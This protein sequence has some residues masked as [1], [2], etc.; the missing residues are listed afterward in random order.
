MTRIN[1]IDPKLLRDK[2]LLAE[3]RELPR[4]FKLIKAAQ[5]RGEMPDD[6]RNPKEYKLGT[7][8]VRFFYDKA[9][10]LYQRQK[11]LIAECIE[12]GFNVTYTNPEVLI[13]GIFPSR[14]NTWEPT[15]WDQW[16]NIQRIKERGGLRDADE[17]ARAS[18]THGIGFDSRA[19]HPIS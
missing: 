10:W 14:C 13:R 1:C 15:Q 5:T 16:I 17:T 3:Y 6:P 2:H 9:E 19:S 4:L 11:A 7:G 8:H 18:K 12:R